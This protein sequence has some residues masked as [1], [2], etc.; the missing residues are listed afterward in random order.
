MRTTTP[1]P[2]VLPQV[3]STE[4]TPF[5]RQLAALLK[6]GVPIL[7][8]LDIL[9]NGHSNPKMTILLRHIHHEVQAGRPLSQ[10]LARSTS[11][12]PL[13]CQLVK[14]GEMAGILD[15][16][17]ERLAIYLEKSA[18][19]KRKVKTALLYPSAVLIMAAIVI[20]L[21]MIYVIPTFKTVFA[22]FG[23]SLPAPTQW[24]IA[25]SDFLTQH[26]GWLLLLGL[27]GGYS[28]HK[29]WRHN[30]NIQ[31]RVD[32]WLL[33]LPVVGSLLTK[34]VLARWLHTLSVLFAAGIPLVAALEAVGDIADNAVYARA[35]RQVQHE[36]ATGTALSQ[37]LLHTKIFPALVS[38]M[39]AVGETSGALEHL[40]LQ[41]GNFYEQ[42]VDS[43][44]AGLASL[45][46]PFIMAILGTLIG[47]IVVAMY[48]PIFKLGQVV[49]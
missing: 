29:V 13:Y 18:T 27:S 49:S 38:Q 20:T 30:P 31:Y 39:C 6:A 46:E 12:S 37:A 42:E 10:A 34:T 41:T 22:S 28:L 14:A 4:T 23:A 43:M 35:T 7:Q 26:A 8:A 40:L 5:T 16:I 36:V 21:I 1:P 32:Q 48:L 24:V 2:R 44:V 19:L 45:L 17:L 3:G 33:H 11:F 9:G 47:S 15:S 25:L